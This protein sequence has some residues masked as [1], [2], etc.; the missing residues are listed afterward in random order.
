MPFAI[1]RSTAC[2]THIIDAAHIKA[3]SA[4]IIHD[5]GSGSQVDTCV[6]TKD[7]TEFVRDVKIIGKR[8]TEKRTYSFKPNNIR[9]V[10]VDGSDCG[11][12]EV[13]V[14]GSEECR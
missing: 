12:Q 6:I 8:M 5:L 4:G 3:R 2:G 7:K 9:K 1:L 14:W 10:V 11:D 13:G